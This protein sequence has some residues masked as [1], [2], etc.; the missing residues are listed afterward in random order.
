MR[1]TGAPRERI[2][3]RAARA[4]EAPLISALALRSKGHWG[5][6]P[7]FLAACREE[8]TLT[9]EQCASGAVR[10]A[11]LDGHLAGFSRLDGAPPE[12]ELEALFVDPP[13][14][15]EGLGA[16]LLDDVLRRAAGSGMRY[17]GLDADP[18]AES[19]YAKH[20]AVTVGRAESGSIPGRMLP[21][22]RFDLG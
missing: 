22:M 20:G 4:E 18:G 11:V 7:E 9:A 14:I 5:Y 8:L 1:P 10:V 3:L 16:A 12:G 13:W 6:S 17:L 21:R 15:G 19:F 2:V